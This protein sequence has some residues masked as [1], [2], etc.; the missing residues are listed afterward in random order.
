MATHYCMQTDPDDLNDPKWPKLQVVGG[1][2]P[3]GT[4]AAV[5]MTAPFDAHDESNTENKR[6][7]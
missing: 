3:R 1:R 4:L 7:S 5:T 2:P 6:N